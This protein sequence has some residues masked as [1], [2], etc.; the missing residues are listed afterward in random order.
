[1]KLKKTLSVLLTVLMIMSVCCIGAFGVG[2][3]YASIDENLYFAE[4]SFRDGVGPKT[5]GVAM[6]YKYF[7]P[8]L[9][10]NT[11]KYPLV[12]WL[13]GIGNGLM[14]SALLSS[15]D[16]KA[17][18]T[19][20]LQSRF[21]D[22]G[23]AFI[24]VPRSPENRRLCWADSLIHTLR[25][26]IDDFIAK[27]K[28]NIDVSR[29]YLGGY[30]MGG[31]MTLKMA[32]AYPEMFAAIFPVCPAWVPDQAGAAKIADI[33][34]WLTSGKPDPIVNYYSMVMPVWENVISQSNVP[35]K[36]R[37]ST[38]EKVTFP[39]GK[40]PYTAHL[41]WYAV[42][43]DMF[44]S[45]DGDYPYMSTVDGNG[46]KVE[47]TYPEGMISWLSEFTSDYDGSP[48]TDSGNQ[49]ATKGSGIL[50]LFAAIINFFENFFSR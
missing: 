7:S 21:K 27:N 30:S 8:T 12:I 13:H 1:M 6:E 31:R 11:G 35:E 44:S 23:G 4:I 19:A 16:I 41:S 45:E 15:S 3:G 38:L 34:M 28:D 18:G 40:R 48:A 25:A 46:N 50:N 9:Y 20:E 5:N 33:P 37:F 26:T 47:L 17:W 36:C 14:E 42:N 43:Y 39:D 10:G 2:S 29:I 22:S 24:L 49:E 32:V